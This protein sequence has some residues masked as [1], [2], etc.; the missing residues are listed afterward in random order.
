MNQQF[1]CSE[2]QKPIPEG[3]ALLVDGQVLCPK[4]ERK[5]ENKHHGRKLPVG[6]YS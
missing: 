3:H 5:F 4:C 1:F 6:V 2:C